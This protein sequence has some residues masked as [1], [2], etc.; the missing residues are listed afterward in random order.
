MQMN[1]YYI[2][3]PYAQVLAAV[4]VIVND[5]KWTHE[6]TNHVRFQF[7]FLINTV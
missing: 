7:P 1:R 4:I 6:W 2:R 3:M 5:D